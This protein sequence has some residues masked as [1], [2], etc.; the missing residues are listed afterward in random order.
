MALQEIPDEQREDDDSLL[1]MIK[2]TQGEGKLRFVW[3]CLI[4]IFIEKGI[5]E[6]TTDDEVLKIGEI[7]Q[8]ATPKNFNSLLAYDQKIKILLF[9]CNSAHDFIAFREYLSERL[10]EKHRYSREKQ[11]TYTDIRRIDGEKKQLMAQHSNSDFVKNES[12]KDKITAL[13]AEQK[14]ASRTRG[15]EIT[16]QLD[17]L[18]KEMNQYYGSMKAFDEKIL[19]LN[20]K[21]SRL[22]DQLF[23]VSVKVS[24]IGYDLENE[25]WYFKDEPTKIY[26]KNMESR[27]WG[28]YSDEE[29]IQEL[30]KSLLTKGSKEKKLCEGLRRLRGK[31]RIKASKIPNPL[32]K[33]LNGESK[34]ESKE[35]ETT[36][37]ETKAPLQ[38][39][40][41]TNGHDV[42]MKADCPKYED[43][44]E[45]VDWEKCDERAIQFST[46]KS[47]MS[48]RRSIR[49][50]VGKLDSLNL[51]SIKDKI[52]DLES[53]YT[54]AS[55]EI[56]KSWTTYSDIEKMRN[57]IIEA[58][59]E[60]TLRNTLE[61]IECGFS[62]PM[63]VKPAEEMPAMTKVDQ[64]SDAQSNT[65]GKPTGNKKIYEEGL[66]FFRNNRK[67][68]KFWSSDALKDSW[69]EYNSNILNGSISA[70]F[71]SV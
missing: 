59:D 54:E 11:D 42:E 37:S 34:E 62:N 26:V 45:E 17:A 67:I 31:M 5:F 32:T 27:Q 61:Y 47:E 46:R 56:G 49:K 29:S 39:S 52:L 64:V 19:S 41:D 1:W 57:I 6:F 50:S 43:Y 70:L 36:K 30:E 3:P 60:E 10:K 14:D 65:S 53:D 7:L 22:N 51:Q 71:L 63:N 24:I 13:R 23:K 28:Y 69:K 2:Q 4:S 33:T 21:I 68:K 55:K 48:T 8:N 35:T 25:Y 15:K 66:V 38:P 58:E 40:P 9:L 20:N 12:V 18:T 16:T 44:K